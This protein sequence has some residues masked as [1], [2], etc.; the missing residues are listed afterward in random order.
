MFEFNSG[1]YQIVNLINNKIYIG[2][3]NN[4]KDR[5]RRH[6]NGLNSGTSPNKKL[7]RSYN[8]HGKE[9]F[10]FQILLY[11]DPENLIFYEQ[12]LL[13]NE[14]KSN[15]Y[16]LKTTA[17]STLGYTHTEESIKKM[18][19]AQKKIPGP[20]KGMFRSEKVKQKM[21]ISLKG[22]P[23]WN[24]GLKISEEQKQKISEA[25][26]GRITSNKLNAESVK[27]IRFMLK[28]HNYRGLQKKL[29]ELY[30]VSRDTIR[31]IDKNIA[32]KT[33]ET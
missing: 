6:F 24:K 13:D 22:K 11:C 26:K 9:S 17:K 16:N 5:K 28:Y 31:R 27:V 15:L 20:F 30:K 14:N 8:K 2:S 12:L 29:S 18:S 1:I 10:E 23:A 25:R 3:S 33:T 21:S 19:Q 32:W 4:L 7:Q